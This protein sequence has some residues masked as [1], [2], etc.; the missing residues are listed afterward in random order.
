[1]LEARQVG[2]FRDDFADFANRVIELFDVDVFVKS[3]SV[4]I[5]AGEIDSRN[6]K[7]GRK[8]R[9][10]G[11]GTECSLKAFAGYVILEIGIVAVVKHGVVRTFAVDF[12]EEF[13]GI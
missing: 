8:K 10:I 12:N 3:M 6:S 9:N 4:V 11:K 13:Q 5:A 1:M 7:C 2:N